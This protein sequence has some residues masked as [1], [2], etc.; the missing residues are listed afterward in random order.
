MA[1]LILTDVEDGVLSRLR[2]LAVR[3][4]R[5]PT[6]EAKAILTNALHDS[7]AHD[8]SAV[9]AI[10]QRLAN[11]GQVFGDS[12]DSIREDRNR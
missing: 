12:V 7:S 6:D 3:H 5:T 11:S 9:D 2:E 8:W 10:Y 1:E 4:G